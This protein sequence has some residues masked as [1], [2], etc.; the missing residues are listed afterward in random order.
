VARSAGSSWRRRIAKRL[1]LAVGALIAEL[2]L[3]E[4]ALSGLSLMPPEPR[5]QV[6]EHADRER[7]N[8]VAD[9]EIGW[10]MRPGAS[11]RWRTEGE[12]FPFLAD[13]QGFRIDER[14]GVPAAAPG[15]PRI[16]LVGDSF[17]FGTG[18]TFADT[19][20]ARLSAALGAV[21][22][23]RAQPGFG[24]DQM[25]RTAE[26]FV[27][28][29]APP[30]LLVV[31]VILDDF[32]RTLHAYRHAEGF[33]KP[34]FRLDDG[35]PVLSGVADNLSGIER[36]LD[37]SSRLYTLG[38]AV[39]RRLGQ[40]HGVGEWWEL[41]AACLSALFAAARAAS[42]PVVVVHI[43]TVAGW[44]RFPA[45]GELV[46]GAGS[47]VA[48]VDLAVEWA[49]P[50]EGAYYPLDGHLNAT[51]HA[52]LADLLVRSVRGRWGDWPTRKR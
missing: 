26:R 48:L 12:E 29:E 19:Y 44:R 41:N 51:G 9:P 27:L 47:D 30:D 35:R 49:T 5:A 34:R 15:A 24:V 40:Q 39:M 32:E 10:R 31:G 17:T 20:G 16:A 43:A 6:G 36:F 52:A 46:A 22:E 8:F 21:A 25:W 1:A 11:F 14:P 38:E 23:N 37:Q 45:L 42:V 2:L 28:R 3:I 18:V 50:P 13:S 33:N 4:A 7:K